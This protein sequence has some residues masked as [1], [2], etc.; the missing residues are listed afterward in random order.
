MKVIDLSFGISDLAEEFS[1]LRIIVD[2][3]AG[4][5]WESEVSRW[6]IGIL[7]V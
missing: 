1:R 7:N 5:Y 2:Y 4:R 3:V 6:T